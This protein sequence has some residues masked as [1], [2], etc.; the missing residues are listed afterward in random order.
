MERL[1][2][3]RWGFESNC[4]VREAANPAGLGF[5]FLADTDDA[6]VDAEHGER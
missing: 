3:S 2:N 6:V 4:F 1:E 5:E